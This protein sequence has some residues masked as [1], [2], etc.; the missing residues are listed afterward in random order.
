MELPPQIPGAH[1]SPRTEDY[2]VVLLDINEILPSEGTTPE[3]LALVRASLLKDRAI[4]K[5]IC[6]EREHKVLMDGHHRLS[7]LRSFGCPLIPVVAFDYSEVTV[8]SW[9]TGEPM[10]YREVIRR[11]LSGDLYPPKTTRH[12]FPVT[13]FCDIPLEALTPIPLPAA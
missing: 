7:I 6:I 13:L 1:I 5:P 4:K 10:D 3:N 2:P 9:A 12:F 11:G 8:V